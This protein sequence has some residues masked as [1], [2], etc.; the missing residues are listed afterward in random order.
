MLV[1]PD[2]TQE[3]P[4]TAVNLITNEPLINETRKVV[5]M[6]L[7]S[8]NPMKLMQRGFTLV[9]LLIVVIILAI[10]AAIVIPQFSSATTDAQEAALDS[11]LNALRSAIDLYK[12]QHNG[13]YPGQVAATGATCG[14]GAAG[15]GA[16]DTEAAVIDQLTKFSSAQGTTCTDVYKRQGTP[17]A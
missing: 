14:V 3:N 15:T 9:E 8:K 11:N 10:L 17:R 16:I 4:V 6:N 2:F 7:N 13:K 5:K 12:V 1:N